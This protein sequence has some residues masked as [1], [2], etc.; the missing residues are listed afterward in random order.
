[1]KIVV[2][3][4]T[5]RTG[6]EIVRMAL[7]D[8]HE[9]KAFV[10]TP[11]KCTPQSNLTVIQGDVRDAQAVK[12]VIEGVDAVVSA[13]GTDG[14]TTLTEATS[15][16]IEGMKA[17]GV[18]RLVTIG[19]AGIL[20]SR[21]QPSKLRYQSNESHRKLTFAAEE[22]H[23]VYDMLSG[24]SLEW[25]IVCPTYLPDGEAAGN[26]RIE[27][28]RLPIEGKQITVGD[29]AAFAYHELIEKQHIGYRVGISY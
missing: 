23:K 8:G 4:A 22:H 12:Q 13:L 19:T 21:T 1:M 6:S 25:T 15:S 17:C 3:G 27:R 26:Y 24:S 9:V 20:E 16:F 2:F 28:D 18:S 10:R 5:G 11:E 7:T 14:T 29:T